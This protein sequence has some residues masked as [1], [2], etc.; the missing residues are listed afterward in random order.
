MRRKGSILTL[1]ATSH[2]VLQEPNG[3]IRFRWQVG[4]DVVH[5]EPIQ[6]GL[7]GELRSNLL[8]EHLVRG[9]HLVFIVRELRGL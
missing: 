1:L 6:F 8:G 2:E 3:D 7:R 9:L 5:E 4:P